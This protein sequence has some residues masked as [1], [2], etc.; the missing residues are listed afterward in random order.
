MASNSHGW[1]EIELH[2]IDFF[3]VF[4]DL[5]EVSWFAPGVCNKIIKTVVIG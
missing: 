3:L 4:S 1:N 2:S 5:R